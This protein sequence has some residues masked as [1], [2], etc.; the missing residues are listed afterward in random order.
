MRARSF[1]VSAIGI[2]CL[3]L[4][5]REAHALGYARQGVGIG[6]G[7]GTIA[8]GL[9]LKWMTGPGAIQGV[10]GFWGGGGIKDRFS[11]VGGVA[12]NL[13]YLFEMPTIASTPYFTIDWSFGLGAGIGVPTTNGKLG[14]AVSGIAGL[15][16][17]FTRVPIDFVVE[18]R[19]TVAVIPDAG[20]HLL[21]ITAHLRLWL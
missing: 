8:N 20:I 17:N 3:L 21:D 10:V 5:T 13:D 1:L 11:N 4:A 7:S 15:E 2:A 16:F 18:L 9:S 14:A 12:G 6:I 19:P